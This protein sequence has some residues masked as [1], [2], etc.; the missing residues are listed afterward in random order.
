V[1]DVGGAGGGGGGGGGQG[2]VFKDGGG[3]GGGGGAGGGAFTLA[4]GEELDLSG[5][6]FALGGDGGNGALASTDFAGDGGGGAGGGGGALLL[7]GVRFPSGLVLALGG[8]NGTHPAHALTV[9]TDTPLQSIMKQPASGT[10]RV[11]GHL[12]ATQPPAIVGPDLEY[13]HDLVSLSPNA[14]IHGFHATQVRVRDRLGN[15]RTVTPSTTMPD[16]SFVADV[17][18]FELFNDVQAEMTIDAAI[19]MVSAPIRR[20]TILF[21]PGTVPV[22]SFSCTIAPNPVTVPTERTV[23][24]SLTVSA[25]Q[26]SP[27]AWSAVGS[28]DAGTVGAVGQGARYQA[29]SSPPSQPVTVRASSMLVSQFACA[30]QVNV[31]AGV[32]VTATAQVG[33]PSDPTIP[34]ANVGQTITASIPPAVLAMTHQGFAAGDAVLFQ[35][36]QPA[37]P[38]GQ[39]TKGSVS[40]QGTVAPGQASLGV[41]VP[42]CADADQMVRVRGHGSARLLV[43][44]LI[45]AL[46]LDPILAPTMLIKGS[47]FICGAT[48]IDFD[49]VPVPASQVFSVTCVLI[50]LS[51]RPMP[52]QT[53]QVKTA[54]GTS[55]G[56]V[57]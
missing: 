6:V 26:P 21:L 17:T 2:W 47:G 13:R 37:A 18:L 43:V 36:V 52:G 57:V 38:G 9:N 55:N 46:D 50:Q 12:T 22:Y 10:I 20:R 32:T 27:I 51:V 5:D 56:L 28:A 33:T 16:G 35:T 14:Q 54:G 30:T 3:G 25:T 19:M 41:D 45:S 42:P 15:E 7:Q 23:D 53:V 11:D 8:R 34:S 4:A 48:E 31:I 29:P 49:G 24:L 1:L 39:C 44:P 40:V